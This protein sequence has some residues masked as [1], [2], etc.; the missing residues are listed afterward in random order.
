MRWSCKLKEEALDCT[1]WKTCFVRAYN[2]TER[3]V[4]DCLMNK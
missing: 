2:P 1:L 3:P 4:A